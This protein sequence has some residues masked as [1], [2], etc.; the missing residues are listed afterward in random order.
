VD[1]ANSAYTVAGR[2]HSMITMVTSFSPLVGSHTTGKPPHS[3]INGMPFVGRR[4]TYSVGN[5][6]G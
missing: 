2:I 6:R 5:T 1:T 4:R 3:K